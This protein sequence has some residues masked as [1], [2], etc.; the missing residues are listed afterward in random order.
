MTCRELID[1]LSDYLDNDLALPERARFDEH[2]AAC[3]ECVLYLRGYAETIRL[4]KAVCRD[5]HDAADEAPE[6]LVQ[7]IL[8]A[9]AGRG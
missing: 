6:A 7:A 8:A 4:G 2:L 5:D 1:F 3:P 9:R